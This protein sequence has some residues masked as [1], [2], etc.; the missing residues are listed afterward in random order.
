[1]CL[2]V[3]PF[4]LLLKQRTG[5]LALRHSLSSFYDKEYLTPV[6]TGEALVRMQV[7]KRSVSKLKCMG[8]RNGYRAGRLDNTLQDD[9]LI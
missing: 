4:A 7:R 6:Y 8:K 5:H 3:T 2:T 9:A 1:M